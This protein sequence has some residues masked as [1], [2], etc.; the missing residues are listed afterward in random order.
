MALA[1]DSAPGGLLLTTDADSA[2]DPNWIA[3]N[4]AA[5]AT[6]DL[7][8]GRLVRSSG[9]PSGKQD[10]IE[11]Y[12]DRLHALR[13]MIDPVHWDGDPTHH[14]TSGASLALGADTYRALGGFQPVASGEDAALCDAASRAGYLVRRDARVVV[15]TSARRRGRIDGGLAST[16]AALDTAEQMPMTFHPEDE[17]WRF[18]LHAAARRLHGSSDHE[19]L[20]R[21]LGL[22][23]A[24]VEQVA[25]ECRNG[26]AFAARIVGTPPGGMRMVGLAHAEL[27]LPALEQ[28]PWEGAA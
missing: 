28:A 16:L 27:L 18:R 2:P 6:A 19:C 23:M 17:A 4:L 14:W 25:R 20:S 11:R 13:R 3:T 1:A 7:V 9:P 22:R 15:R 24:E 26:E 5:L 12:Y 8:A 10:R 21:A